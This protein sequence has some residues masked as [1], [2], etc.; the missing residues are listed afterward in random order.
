MVS[1]EAYEK[2]KKIKE[3]SPSMSYTDI[4]INSLENKKKPFLELREAI[5]KMKLRKDE[6]KIEKELKKGWTRWTKRYA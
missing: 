1:N 4:I 6:K 2:L 5:A 3:N